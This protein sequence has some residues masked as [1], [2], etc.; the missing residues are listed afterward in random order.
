MSLVELINQLKY[1]GDSE[2]VSF[3]KVAYH[4]AVNALMSLDENEFLSLNDFRHIKGIGESI[5]TKILEYKSNGMIDKLKNDPNLVKHR[6]S[7]DTLKMPREEMELFILLEL[8]TLYQDLNVKE[9][10][11]YRRLLPYISDVD[12]VVESDHYELLKSRLANQFEI[13]ASGDTKSS[14]KVNNS[15]STQIDLVKVEKESMPFA[16]LHFTGSKDHNIHLRSIAKK[17]GYHLNEYGLTDENGNKIQCNSE[18]D[19]FNRLNLNYVEPQ[20]R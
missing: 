13:L 3:K 18:E 1:L 11:S 9:C 8:S 7:Y 14:F 10:G 19:I 20:F 12:L 5:N 16:L 2:T 17:L 4:K 6:A 15:Y